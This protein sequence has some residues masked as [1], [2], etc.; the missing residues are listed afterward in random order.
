MMPPLLECNMFIDAIRKILI[1][2]DI[3]EKYLCVGFRGFSL[4]IL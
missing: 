4:I 1:E 3:F 2:L